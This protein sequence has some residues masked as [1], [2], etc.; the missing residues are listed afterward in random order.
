MAATHW[1]VRL[2]AMNVIVEQWDE[3]A[4][5]F[6]MA[7]SSERCYTAKLLW[8]AYNDPQNKLYMVFTRKVLKGSRSEKD[9][10]MSE[11]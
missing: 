10:S 7:A 9:L 5:H 3:L 4:F 8:E 6:Q 1:L 2:E 11:C